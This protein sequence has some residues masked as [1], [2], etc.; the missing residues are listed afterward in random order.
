MSDIFNARI[1]RRTVLGA[2][3]AGAS[4]LAMPAVLRAQDKSLKVGVYGGYFKDSFDKNIFPDFTKATGIAVESIAE[5]TGEA[6]LVQ[7]EQAAKAGAAPADVSMMSQVAMLKGQST[8]LWAPLDLSK[9]PNAANLIERFVNKYP[10]GRVAGIGAVS[11]YITLVSNTDVFKDAPTSWSA[12]WE[13]DKE[14]KLGLLALVSNSF[15]LE[16]TAKTFMGGTS[17]LD[18]DEGI[19]KAL[20]KL[21]EL[22]P[23]V[24]LW[25][26]DE[27]Q[28]EQALKSG[29]IPMGQYYH[30][31]TGLAVAD[32][33]HVRST[34]PKE[35]GIQDSGCWALSRASQK[36]EEAHVFIDYMCQPAIQATLSRKVGTSP[37][38]QRGLTDLTDQEFAAVSS[39]IEPIVPRYD[40]YQTKSDFLNQKW[41]EMIAG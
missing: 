20:E 32:G 40:L 13:K 22:K 33:F 19:I 29:E 41:T 17:A 36:T 28:F 30:D 9:L 4:M 16:V 7:L 14:D 38:V 3:V 23:N 8:E 11:W 12:L 24:R 10:D 25:Y 37:T 31:V 1:G 35:G 27:A 15:L 39:D 34:F 5:P 21:A 18:T 6:W 26:R 2:G